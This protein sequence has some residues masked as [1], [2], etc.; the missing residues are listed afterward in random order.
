MK[1]KVLLI[2]YIVGTA[3]ACLTEIIGIFVYKASKKLFAES[4]RNWY[5][6]VFA[7]YETESK[8]SRRHIVEFIQVTFNC[9]GLERGKEDYSEQNFIIPQTCSFKTKDLDGRIVEN[10]KETGCITALNKSF[11]LYVD[12]PFYVLPVLA[13]LQLIGI[14]TGLILLNFLI[15]NEELAQADSDLDSDLDDE[16]RD[17]PMELPKPK[18]YRILKQQKESFGI[19]LDYD[20]ERRGHIVKRIN[21][22]SNTEFAG[23]P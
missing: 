15:K 11:D 3:V 4:F 16:D 12:I 13:C 17:A 14:I 7:L 18:L 6:G 23:K 1:N 10:Y 22:N 21:E 9:C 8:G 19:T 5:R 20:E 2:C